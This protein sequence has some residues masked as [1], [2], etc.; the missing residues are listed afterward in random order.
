MS[1]LK[2][3]KSIGYYSYLII[4]TQYSFE[5]LQVI[6]DY[7]YVSLSKQGE[8]QIIVEIVMDP[9]HRVFPTQTKWINSICQVCHGRIQ[10]AL[11]ENTDKWI[12]NEVTNRS[13]Y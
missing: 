7:L 1:L 3:T 8:L 11:A 9:S 5:S 12:E 13:Y 10:Q 4:N 6:N 2:K